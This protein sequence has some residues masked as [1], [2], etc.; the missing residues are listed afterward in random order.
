MKILIIHNS[1][2]ERGGEDEVVESEAKLLQEHGHKIIFYRR[3]NKE[4]DNLSI[5]AKISLL[6][7]GIIW[8]ESVYNEIKALIKRERPDIAH[9]HNIFVRISPSVYFALNEENIPVVQT[10]HNYRLVCP[11]SILYRNGRVCDDCSDSQFLPAIIHRC[12]KES[13]F[14]TLALARALRVHFRR[15]TFQ[16]KVGAYIVM[17]RFSKNRFIKAGL[18]EDKIFIKPN[19]VELNT[20]KKHNNSNFCLFVGRLVDYK[21]IEF[22]VEIFKRLKDYKLKVIGDGPLIEKLK[23]EVH[24]TPN[25]ELLGRMTHN[26]TIEYMR[27]TYLLIF[28]SKCYEST[29]R[30]IVEAFA[31]GTPVLVSDRGFLGDKIDKK[32]AGL[33]FKAQDSDD[34]TLKIKSVL[35]NKRL[36]EQMGENA[37]RLYRQKYTPDINY[38]ILMGIYNKLLT[39]NAN[40]GTK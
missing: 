33:S 34:F 12:W 7:K 14:P 32:G 37:L 1:Y 5:V 18:P 27:R 35:K 10:L 38:N 20:P 22:L 36:L 28:P 8:S 19:F 25:I 26:R 16:N 21:G 17:S 4:I 2:L 6:T 11:K 24:E 30:T 39:N 13:F 3:S 31:C 9:V 23:A 29:P 15:R 40:G